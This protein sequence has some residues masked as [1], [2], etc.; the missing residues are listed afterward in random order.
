MPEVLS[1]GTLTI[2]ALS[3]TDHVLA[4]SAVSSVLCNSPYFCYMSDANQLKLRNKIISDMRRLEA[5]KGSK[6]VVSVW[7]AA[8]R[9]LACA[10][11]VMPDDTEKEATNRMHA[12]WNN[13]KRHATMRVRTEET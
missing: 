5:T 2:C 9:N 11:W 7:H 10:R 12:I 6:F 8:R 13:I 4:Q 1:I 3:F